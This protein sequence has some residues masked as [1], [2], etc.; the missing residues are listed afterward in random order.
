MVTNPERQCR[1]VAEAE[2]DGTPVDNR[3]I[4]LTDDGGTHH[5]RIV[6]GSRKTAVHPAVGAVTS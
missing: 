5:V 3:A 4:P 6:L 1:G 2:L